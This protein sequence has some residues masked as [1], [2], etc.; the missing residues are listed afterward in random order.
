M[1]TVHTRRRTRAA[2]GRS[3]SRRSPPSSL[4]P[5]ARR[6]GRRRGRQRARRHRAASQRL[7]RV[8]ISAVRGGGRGADLAEDAH[9]VRHRAAVLRPG[10]AAR[11]PGRGAVAHR[12]RRD[13]QLLGLQLHP[14]ARH[15]S[16]ADQPDDRRHSAQRSGRSGALL[17][18]LS[19]SREQPAIG[20]GAA[21]RR[22]EQQRHRGLR[23]LDQHG[24]DPARRR[25]ARGGEVQ[26]E[27]GSF[28][29]MRASAEYR[30][31]CCRADSPSYARVSGAADR[32]LPLSL[33]RRGKLGVLQRRLLRR[34]R[35]REAHRDDRH[36]ARHDGVSRRRQ[37]RSRHESPHQ[38]A[39]AATSATDSASGSRRCRTRGCSARR[40]RSRR[41]RIASRRAATTTCVIDSLWNFNLDFAWYGATS[42]WSYRRDAAA[43]RRRRERQHV[44][45]RPLRVS[46]GRISTTPLYFNTGHK[47]DASAFGKLGVHR[48]ARR[49]CSAICRR[50]T[51]DFRYTPDAHAGDRRSVDR[52]VVRES[53][54]GRDVRGERAA[55]AVRVVRHRTRASRRAATCSPAST[56]STRRTWRSSAP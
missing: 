4:T 25:R 32:R 2:L 1:I 36:D 20:A 34:S 44:R 50:G 29:S 26:L 31:D 51:R 9:A 48:R 8:M 39:H 55:V 15:R 22:H 56:T 3:R 23:G 49:R 21:R 30:A 54:G 52:L 33:G 43:A 47:Q 6:A 7:E 41:R 13:R 45:A 40:R 37:R 18:G 16:V 14:A 10:R 11:A 42:A 5:V 28:G 17:R 46:S 27:G 19:G 35:H 38:S 24:N 12:V 53:E